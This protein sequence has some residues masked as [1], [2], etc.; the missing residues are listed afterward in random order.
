MPIL[1]KLQLFLHVFSLLNFILKLRI[2]AL[3]EN[4]I[5]II[6]C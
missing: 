5:A 3:F 4:L 1:I 6:S 2:L